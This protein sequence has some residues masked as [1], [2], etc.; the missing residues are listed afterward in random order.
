MSTCVTSQFEIVLS[1]R[2]SQSQ[3]SSS[4]FDTSE[5]CRVFLTLRDSHVTTRLVFAF[6]SIHQYFG[7]MT[8]S[9]RNAKLIANK[10]DLAKVG[11]TKVVFA[12]RVSVSR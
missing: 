7:D 4:Q 2:L 5:I 1:S 12:F 8:L 3:L 6:C 9:K 11:D 10:I